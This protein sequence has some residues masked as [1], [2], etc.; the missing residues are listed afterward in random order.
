MM[1]LG[2]RDI[3]APPPRRKKSGT[4]DL[5]RCPV[6]RRTGTTPTRL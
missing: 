5:I 3:T 1:V 4:M 6:G 2:A